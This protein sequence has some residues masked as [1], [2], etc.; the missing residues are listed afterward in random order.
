MLLINWSG[1]K[2]FYGLPLFKGHRDKRIWYFE[3]K[4]LGIQIT[5]YSIEMAHQ[6]LGSLNTLARESQADSKESQEDRRYG[7]KSKS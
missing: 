3:V 2:R 4:W 6:M 7:P 1:L 5:L